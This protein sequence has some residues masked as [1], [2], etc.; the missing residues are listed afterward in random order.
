MIT[1]DPVDLSALSMTLNIN[2]TQPNMQLLI[3]TDHYFSHQLKIHGEEAFR[4]EIIHYHD[5]SRGHTFRNYHRRDN[6]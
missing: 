3:H 5:A 4:E 2:V 1:S 6:I